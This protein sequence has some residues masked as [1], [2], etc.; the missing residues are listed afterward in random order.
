MSVGRYIPV[1]EFSPGPRTGFEAELLAAAESCTGSDLVAVPSSGTINITCL[2]E[3]AEPTPWLLFTSTLTV[4]YQNSPDFLICFAVLWSFGCQAFA[5][6]G[7][8]PGALFLLRSHPGAPL[9]GP[10]HD[11][12]SNWLQ[13]LSPCNPTNDKLH[14]LPKQH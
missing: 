14:Y 4:T 6:Q 12:I 1:F 3:E 13:L 8:L 5:Q 10:P 11:S 2:K 9:T 7:S